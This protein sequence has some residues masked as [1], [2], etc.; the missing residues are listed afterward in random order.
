MRIYCPKCKVGYEIDEAL[1]PAAGKKLRCSYCQ[2]VFT[3]H[4]EDLIA[5]PQ[6]VQP[7]LEQSETENDASA[8]MPETE[9]KSFSEPTTEIK[10]MFQRLAEQ[11]ENLVKEE[12][13]MPAYKKAFSK[14]KFGLGLNR[15]SNRRVW[16]SALILLALLLL[17]NYRYE[18]VRAV[19]F[20]NFVYSAVGIK[21]RIPGEGLEF[22]N[23]SWNKIEENGNVML[24]VKGFI[25]NPTE[26]EIAIPVMRVEM[27][28]KDALLLQSVNQNPLLKSLKPGGRVA[29]SVIIKKP[30]PNAKYV[31]LTFIDGLN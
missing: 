23:I 30:V 11:S 6:I 21:A 15:R 4:R 5:A 27:L 22:Q 25:H 18:V 20:L 7:F 12:L 16:G 1:I 3:A 13:E 14:F 17:Y 28:D 31:Y 9:E 29:V 19:P 26:S 24:E 8:N 10:D 2:E